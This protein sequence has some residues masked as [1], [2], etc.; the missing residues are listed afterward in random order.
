MKTLWLSLSV[1]VCLSAT[2]LAQM[3]G[4]ALRYDPSNEVAIRGTVVE[5]RS[6]ARPGTPHGTY[7][8]LKTPTD[9]LNVHLGPRRWSARGRVSLAAGEPVEVVGCVVSSRGSQI[10]LAREVRKAGS[11][12]TFR[13]ARGFQD[14]QRPQ[15]P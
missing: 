15:R 3:T 1:L 8:V 6:M 11:V 12:L 13:N 9:T 5:V 14:A 7:L 2:A 4:A 10:V